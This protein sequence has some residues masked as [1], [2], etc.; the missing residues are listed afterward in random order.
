MLPTHRA[1][2]LVNLIGS[3]TLARIAILQNHLFR[4]VLCQLNPCESL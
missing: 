4:I 2:M 3:E 1:I